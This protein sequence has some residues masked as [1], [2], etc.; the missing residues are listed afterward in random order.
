MSAPYSGMKVLELA[1]V[2][3]MYCGKILAGLGAEVIKI[4]RPGGDDSRK[5]GPFFHGE[6]G[7][8]NSL[9]FIYLN[10]GKKDITL[11]LATPEG[12]E[13]FLQLAKDA[14]AV[15]ETYEPGTLENWGLGYD[16]L[17]QVNPGLILLSITPFGQT[18]P[19]SHWQAST[20][21]IVDAV[22]G[23][24]HEVGYVDKPPLHMGYD[25]QACGLSM[26]GLFAL[27]AAYH[28]RKFTKKG[29]HIDLAQSES[30]TVWRDQYLGIVQIND[31]DHLPPRK[32]TDPK[33]IRY[34]A[35]ECKDG[36]GYLII[37]GKWKELVQWFADSGMDVSVFDDPKYD[38]YMV[39]AIHPW[40]ENIMDRVT[41]L[42]AQYTTAE[43]MKEGQRRH[44]PAGVVE[45]PASMLKNEQL[46]ERGYFV[47]L[48]HPV[49]GKVKYPGA[50][51]ILTQS[52]YD[53][54][55][56]A[57][58]LGADNDEIYEKLGL[59]PEARRELAARGVI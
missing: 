59:S 32:S 12:K 43:F 48:E 42:A 26:Y 18:G 19:H 7:V 3:G 20:D 49:I 10:T 31:E 16:V 27:Q 53:M 52:P 37:G 6:K 30:I 24:M 5:M 38:I 35:V 47:E 17:S 46:L 1:N 4:E 2:N 58:T 13:L 39:D 15:I 21:L 23:P 9:S 50:P 40:D 55:R 34:K 44:I 54:G 25:I 45:D 29:A 28:N 56:P 8:E 14:D 11:D 41:K 22:A 33:S 51:A 36:F 57:P